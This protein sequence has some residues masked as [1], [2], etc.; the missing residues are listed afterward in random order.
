MIKKIFYII[1]QILIYIIWPI[2]FLIISLISFRYIIL[3]TSL[4]GLSLLLLIK[5]EI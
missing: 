4:A 2:I 5:D 3:I 1:C